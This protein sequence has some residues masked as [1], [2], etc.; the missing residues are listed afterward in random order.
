MNKSTVLRVARP[1]DNL[2]QITKMYQDGLGFK[3]LASFKDHDGF[4]GVIIGLESH[5]YHLEFTQC[6]SHKAGKAPTKDNLLVFY[7]PEK[8]EW[9][10]VCDDME[11]AGFMAV[12]SF[13]PYWDQS[14]KTFE[15]IDGYRIVIQNG[16]WLGQ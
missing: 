1:T 15:D 9:V 10:R 5:N 11:K 8:S 7:V 4:D 3:V 16:R 6:V 2:D 12:S 14:G 13:N